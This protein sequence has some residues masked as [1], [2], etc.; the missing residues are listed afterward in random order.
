MF[1]MM[2]LASRRSS[3]LRLFSSFARRWNTSIIA[4]RDSTQIVTSASL[5][6]SN[7]LWEFSVGTDST[8]NIWLSPPINDPLALND[9]HLLVEIRRVF[10]D[11]VLFFQHVVGLGDLRLLWQTPVQT[12]Q[13]LNAAPLHRWRHIQCQI[14][15]I[16]YPLINRYFRLSIIHTFGDI[17]LINSFRK[18]NF[19]TSWWKRGP[20]F[21]MHS[22][23]T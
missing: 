11:D 16:G 15:K 20:H 6:L 23:I 19:P 18:R 2:R 12:I 1:L 4:T 13:A 10:R 8:L 17:T 3:A 7:M 22:S 9:R 5:L 14:L 21:L